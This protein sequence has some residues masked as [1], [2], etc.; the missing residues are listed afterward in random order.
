MFLG[1]SERKILVFWS[2]IES[3]LCP[4]A[5]QDSVCHLGWDL[6]LSLH[7][8]S[9]LWRDVLLASHLV[10]WLTF[11]SKHVEVL[12]C[13]VYGEKKMWCLVLSCSY[14]DLDLDLKQK[15]RYFKS[16]LFFLLMLDL[17]LLLFCITLQALLVDVY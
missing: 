4:W 7:C 16:S 14:K 8:I 15:K 12:S 10:T 9:P 13:A 5:I 3:Q 17:L 1:Q 11:S 2:G 6:M